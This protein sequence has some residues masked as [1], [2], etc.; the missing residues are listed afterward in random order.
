MALKSNLI[1]NFIGQG[2]TALVGIVFV[3]LYIN[4]LGIEAYGIVGMF[5]MLSTLLGILDMGM[6]PTL[7]REMARLSGG[8]HTPES[9]RD[10]L[11]TFEIIMVAISISVAFGIAIGS[12]WIA[13]SWMNVESL[14]QDVV[15]RAVAIMGSVA[16]FRFVESMYRSSLVGLQRQVLLNGLTSILATIRGVGAIGVLAWVSPTIDAFFYWQAITSLVTLISVR[17]AVY[18]AL[19]IAHRTGRFSL[20][21]LSSVW[22]FAGGMLGISLLGLLLSQVDKLLLSKLL[23]LSEFGYYSLAALVASIVGML[24]G[25]IVQAWYPHLCDLYTRDDQTSLSRSFHKGAQL[26]SVFAGS[27]AIILILFSNTLLELWTRDDNLTRQTAPI[28]VVLSFGNL[29]N[30]MLWIPYQAQLANGWSSLAVR[31]NI[32]SVLVITPVIMWA[33]IR[34]GALGAAWAWVGLNVSHLI[35]G[36]HFMFRRILIG[37][38]WSWYLKDILIPTGASFLAAYIVKSAWGTPIT[39]YENFFLVAVTTLVTLSAGIL[40]SDQLRHL[41][42]RTVAVPSEHVKAF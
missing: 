27:A 24:V 10:L 11:R 38:K 3:P 9:I 41:V 36:E 4:Y 37:E 34:F 39:S 13:T 35:I 20:S 16:G 23:T 32:I 18:K 25:P 26:M 40:A 15:V 21:S 8:G 29:V 2:W 5:A 33:S 31:I 22:R 30:S 6:T 12:P 19:P 17:I 14:S 7:S 1:A 42:F 28:L